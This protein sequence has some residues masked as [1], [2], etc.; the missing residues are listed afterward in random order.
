MA[1]LYL[2]VNWIWRVFWIRL[3]LQKNSLGLLFWHGLA[4]TFK[5]RLY[6]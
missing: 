2:N 6:G 1:I 4:L 5:G 3:S